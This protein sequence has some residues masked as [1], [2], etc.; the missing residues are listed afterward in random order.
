MTYTTRQLTAIRKLLLG[1]LYDKCGEQGIEESELASQ[2]E[3]LQVDGCL[4]G[5][6]IQDFKQ[7][8]QLREGEP[9]EMPKCYQPSD[10]Q[11]VEQVRAGQVKAEPKEETTMKDWSRAYNIAKSQEFLPDVEVD[12]E[13]DEEECVICKASE[14]YTSSTDPSTGVTTYSQVEGAVPIRQQ[15][16]HFMHQECINKLQSAVCPM[17]RAVLTAV[18]LIDRLQKKYMMFIQTYGDD[19]G[20]IYAWLNFASNDPQQFNIYP[21]AIEVRDLFEQN[22]TVYQSYN[23]KQIGKILGRNLTM[24]LNRYNTNAKR[25]QLMA[26]VLFDKF[27]FIS[28]LIDIT[29]NLPFMN[30]LKQ[31]PSIQTITA[32]TQMLESNQ[33][34]LDI[35]AAFMMIW[36]MLFH[37]IRVAEWYP[38]IYTAVQNVPTYEHATENISDFQKYCVR[39]MLYT[40]VAAWFESIGKRF[41][42]GGDF[43][44]HIS[45][46]FDKLQPFQIDQL[47]SFTSPIKMTIFEIFY[48]LWGQTLLWLAFMKEYAAW[49]NLLTSVNPPNTFSA[50][51]AGGIAER[52]LPIH[53]QVVLQE[54]NQQY[55]N[56]G[57]LP[58]LLFP[59]SPQTVPETLMPEQPIGIPQ[60]FNTH[61]DGILSSSV[62]RDRI[63]FIQAVVHTPE[64]PTRAK[65]S[66]FGMRRPTRPSDEDQP[67]TSKRRL[68]YR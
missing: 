1:P 7:V 4:Q 33:V 66:R 30:L 37:Q 24:D 65:P 38:Y 49:M 14:L 9:G 43:D 16:G 2:L 56:Q 28:G 23:F 13:S 47:D 44:S 39:L 68:D 55:L 22:P 54:W 27:D 19:Q 52:F 32:V 59:S 10:R 3:K 53:M 31:S 29:N 67:P 42:E 6:T 35:T 46:V 25:V 45:V 48:K 61:S 58:R 11:C 60:V 40:I 18:P 12:E 34:T 21:T 50:L 62:T 64:Q 63:K 8:C 26:T 41:V 57:Q 36:F 20:D 5:C 15:C 51:L 17:C